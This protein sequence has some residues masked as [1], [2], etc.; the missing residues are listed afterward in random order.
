MSPFAYMPQ[1]IEFA[2]RGWAAVIVM[3]RGYGGSA[4][5]W[6]ETSGPCNNRDSVTSATTSAADLRAAIAHLT[7]RED[8]DATRIVG[9]GQSAGGLATVA[10]TAD[11]PANLVA[12]ISFAGGRGSRADHD[13]CR[14]DRL[15]E[16]MRNLGRRHAAQPVQLP[17]QAL[18][19]PHAAGARLRG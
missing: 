6:V 1:A 14:E 18:R 15:V 12:G 13:V 19:R 11:P 5:N 7:R 3:R 9:V 10:F 17:G 2:R 4:G 16:A 8:I